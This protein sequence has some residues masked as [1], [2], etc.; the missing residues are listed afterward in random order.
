VNLIRGGGL[1]FNAHT[2]QDSPRD[3]LKREAKRFLKNW[4]RRPYKLT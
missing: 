3:K 2:H 4:S 1:K